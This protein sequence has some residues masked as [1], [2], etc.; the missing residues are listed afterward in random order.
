MIDKEAFNP[1]RLKFARERRGYTI[2]ALAKSIGISSKR[3]SDFENGR[4]I[5]S[6]E[7]FF[8][9]L[10]NTLKFPGTFFFMDDIQSLDNTIVSFRSLARMSARTRNSAL[11]AGRIAL[12]FNAWVEKK[13]DLPEVD[14]PDLKS[15]QPEVAASTLRAHW[16]LG[17]RSIKN[18]TQFLETKGIRIFSL[19]ETTEDMDAFSFWN[20]GRAFIFLNTIKTVERSR[21]DAAHELGHLVLHNH[22][23]PKGKDAEKEANAFASAFLMPEG[24]V[25]ARVPPYISLDIVIELKSCWLVSA[26]AL[27]RRLKDLNLISEWNYRSLNVELSSLGY[28]KKEPHPIMHREQSALIPKIFQFLRDDGIKKKDIANELG[29]YNAEL[30]ALFSNLTLTGI[31]G[32]NGKKPKTSPGALPKLTLLS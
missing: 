32:G 13:L 8:I 27:I 15:I 20:E 25:I 30:D 22:S 21:F 17:E 5:P 26:S 6:K 29:I 31:D 7:D 23:L 14:L 3:L 2:K 11:C 1:N 19:H 18:L 12:E 4:A 24:S 9:S 16:L 28:R 10:S